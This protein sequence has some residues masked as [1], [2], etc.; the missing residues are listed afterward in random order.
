VDIWY[1]ELDKKKNHVWHVK[2]ESVLGKR[3]RA[4]NELSMPVNAIVDNINEQIFILDPGNS[5]IK[6][7]SFDG[8]FLGH[9]RTI[10]NLVTVK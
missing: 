5:R 2:I 3:G 10:D 7:L 4:D 1:V 9:I 6:C 8:K